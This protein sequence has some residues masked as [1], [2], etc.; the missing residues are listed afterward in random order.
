MVEH[1][2]LDTIDI[3]ILMHRDVHFGGNFGIMLDYYKKNGIGSMPDFDE[4]RIYELKLAE[5]QQE[6]D[7]SEAMLPD[8]A[9]TQ[10]EKAKEMYREL[11]S[12]YE[13]DKGEI[14]T[15]LSDLILA[16]DDD[17]KEEIEA[18]VHKS[19]SIVMPLCE[20]LGTDLLFDPLY[21]G[22][23]RAPILAAKCLEKIQDTRAI[24]PLFQA[25]GQDNFFTDEAIIHALVSFGG[26]A[27]AFLIQRLTDLPYS[28]DNE[29]AAIALAAF[30][31][32]EEIANA[33]MQVLRSEDLAKHVPLGIY[34]ACGLTELENESLRE[35]FML[36]GERDTL[37]AQVKD[38]I[39]LIS[40]IWRKNS[41]N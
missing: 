40:S 16:E 22:Y 20:L 4:T 15:L 13:E 8:L 3:E 39:K 38:E 21:P 5:E 19:D 7:L 14:A 2:L 26:Q 37:H 6:G 30:Q 29:R 35:E 23:G 25:L 33:F 12:V 34:A 41:L 32:D 11:R 27:K 28:K 10:V 17:P 9:K 1:P 24:D 31:L 18:I 36:L